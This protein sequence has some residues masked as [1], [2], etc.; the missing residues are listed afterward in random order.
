MHFDEYQAKAAKTAT[1]KGRGKTAGLVYVALGLAGEAGEVAN[2]VKKILRGDKGYELTP[3]VK[4]AIIDE[5][6]DVSWYLSQLCEELGIGMAEVAQR[7]LVKL[8][9]R[10]KRGVL[11]GSGD[12]R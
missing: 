5:A 9:D 7:N 10:A 11:K 1:Y 6:G 2:K 4:A 8:A 3:E 12:S